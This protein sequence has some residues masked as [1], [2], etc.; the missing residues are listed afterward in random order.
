MARSR[1]LVYYPLIVLACSVLGG[2]Y[3]PSLSNSASAAAAEDDV[4]IN[5]KSF[6]RVYALVE[7]NFAD[8]PNP[9][10]A[11][12]KGAIPG[13]LR[14]LD[15]HSNFYDPHEFKIM[16]EDQ[17]GRYYGVGMVIGPSRAGS[18]RTICISPFPGSPAYKAGI[19][20]GDEILAVNDQPVDKLTMSE[21]A[22]RL[23]GARGTHVTVT[24]ARAGNDVPLTFD[25]IR[26]EI[27]RK[28]VGEAFWYRPGIAYVDINS[29]NDNT[30]R[31][32]EDSLRALGEDNFE[33]LILDLRGDPGGLLNE[34]VS[35]AGRFLRR[36]QVVVSHRG[37]ASGDK[38]HRARNANGNH[39][40]PIV[41]LVDGSTASAAEIVA[42]ALQD[43]DRGWVL[44]EQTFGKGL[45]QTV[46]PLS[47]ESGL[48][49]TT[50]RYYTP[51]GRLIQRDY[52]NI[53]FYDYYFNKATDQKN[54]SDAKSTDSGRLVYGGGGITPDEKY[55][56]P[57]LG[58]FQT[59]VLRKWAFFNFISKYRGSHDLKVTKGWDPDQPV[60]L[61]FREFLIEQGV[62]F[63][64][65]DIAR[66]EAWIRRELK[67]EMYSSAFSID[68]AQRLAIETDPQ[69]VKAVEAMPR[70]RALL[71]N[72]KRILAQRAAKTD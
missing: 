39:D 18:G 31:E 35:V 63:D 16:R 22:D 41:I 38:P 54:L 40:Y 10:K 42:G 67:K 29:F 56:P 65:A 33:G 72:A 24:M 34:A 48:A 5:V 37:R 7:Q 66:D 8:S 21:I 51:S 69:M 43:H 4:D 19:R 30:T 53:S 60:L 17:H 11:I 3:G 1:S 46:Y 32:L 52:S 25:L 9:E 70:A 27:P 55:T 49:L 45:V 26:D 71:E 50:A 58:G 13:M 59:A 14:T 64:E 12:Y 28:T 62:S 15:P 36:D 6:S 2:V 68:V 20:P 61:A 57:K 44:G 23:K 47:E